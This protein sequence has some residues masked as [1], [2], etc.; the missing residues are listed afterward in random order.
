VD[1]AQSDHRIRYQILW[2]QG[3]GEL[4]QLYCDWISWFLGYQARIQFLVPVP[5]GNIQNLQ[6]VAD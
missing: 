3:M 2:K 1:I 4:P 5:P 6:L